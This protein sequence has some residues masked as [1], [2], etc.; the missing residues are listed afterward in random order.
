MKT[1]KN[2]ILE[3]LKI[4]KDSKIAE[5]IPTKFSKD[6]D[7]TKEE[8]NIIQN[9]IQQMNVKPIILTNYRVSDDKKKLNEYNNTIFMYYDY[10]WDKIRPANYIELDKRPWGQDKMIHITMNNKFSYEVIRVSSYNIEDIC[11]KLID[12]LQHSMFYEYVK[13]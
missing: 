8:I 9:Y 5:P 3:R 1:L 12:Y 6:I 4:N 10:D 13:K 7:F 2:L 11:K